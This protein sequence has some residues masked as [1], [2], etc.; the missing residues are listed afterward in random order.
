MNVRLNT[1]R[2]GPDGGA[3]A[4]AIIDLDEPTAR[5]LVARGYGDLVDDDTAKPDDETATA[6]R[7]GQ[8]AALKS[9]RKR[10]K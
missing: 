10:A 7:K 1:P 5:D 4:G 9:R 3:H 8:T 6:P 2:F